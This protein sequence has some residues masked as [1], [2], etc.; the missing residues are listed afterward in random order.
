M[1]WRRFVAQLSNT[2][3]RVSAGCLN[4]TWFSLHFLNNHLHVYLVICC[5]DVFMSSRDYFYISFVLNVNWG[6]ICSTA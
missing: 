5:S 6:Q 2:S 1:N 4:K 3:V